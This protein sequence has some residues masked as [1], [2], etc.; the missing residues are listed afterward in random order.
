MYSKFGAKSNTHKTHSTGCGRI[1]MNQ[2]SLN[3]SEWVRGIN[4]LNQKI[5]LI[6]G[7]GVEME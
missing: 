6:E 7:Y 2:W 1:R 3:R 5:R 4:K